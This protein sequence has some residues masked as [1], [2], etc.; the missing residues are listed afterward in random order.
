MRLFYW[1]YTI[2]FYWLVIVF[3]LQCL[4]DRWDD[5]TWIMDTNGMP[6][7]L[8]R[9]FFFTKG[10]QEE[11]RG[12]YLLFT[13]SSHPSPLGYIWFGWI[14]INRH[15]TLC[16]HSHAL[17]LYGSLTLHIICRQA[18]VLLFAYG[19]KGRIGMCIILAG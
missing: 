14:L 6:K 5:L 12:L 2:D 11:I 10:C 15:Y 13:S 16:V 3:Y 9:H 19:L 7:Q 8:A 18:G 1:V 17:V 4:Q